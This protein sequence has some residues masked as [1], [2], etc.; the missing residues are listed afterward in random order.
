MQKGAGLVHTHSTVYLLAF[1]MP[2]FKVGT[3]RSDWVH[4]F[5]YDWRF[6]SCASGSHWPHTQQRI[7]VVVTISNRNVGNN[8]NICLRILNTRPPPSPVFNHV[9][10]VIHSKVGEN[11]QIWGHFLWSALQLNP[12]GAAAPNSHCF[13]P[14]SLY[15]NEAP[16]PPTF[17]SRVIWPVLESLVVLA[18]CIS[19]APSSLRSIGKQIESACV[20]MT[21]QTS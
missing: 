10:Q 18:S 16:F 7:D 4:F 11:Q 14:A 1:F 8:V 20:P 2:P 12:T 13:L 21:L 5:S 6:C 19:G 3:A 17:D 15:I 9:F